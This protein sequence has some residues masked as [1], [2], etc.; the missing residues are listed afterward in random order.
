MSNLTMLGVTQEVDL[1]SLKLLRGDLNNEARGERD[2]GLL[3]GLVMSRV[4][5]LALGDRVFLIVE[6]MLFRGFG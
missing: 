1:L 5:D 4:S 3:G 6:N 2:L